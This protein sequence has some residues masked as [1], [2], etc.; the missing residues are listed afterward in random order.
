[1]KADHNQGLAV[2]FP[3]SRTGSGAGHTGDNRGPRAFQYNEDD[4]THLVNPGYVER[5]LAMDRQ[6]NAPVNY[7]KYSPQQ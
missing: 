5:V 4:S 3:D 2:N 7:A 1:M 6:L